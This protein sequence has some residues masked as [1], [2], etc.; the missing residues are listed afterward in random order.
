MPPAQPPKQQSPRPQPKSTS[1]HHDLTIQSPQP[2]RHPLLHHNHHSPSSAS[3]R[4][5][6]KHPHAPGTRSTASV[7]GQR[8][9]RDRARARLPGDS[10]RPPCFGQ[11]TLR[12]PRRQPPCFSRTRTSKPSLWKLRGSLGYYSQGPPGQPWSVA[13][14]PTGSTRRLYNLNSPTAS[15]RR[16]LVTHLETAS[17][18]VS[19]N[20]LEAL[21]RAGS[22]VDENGTVDPSTSTLSHWVRPIPFGSAE[23]NRRECDVLHTRAPASH[24]GGLLA[25]RLDGRHTPGD[26]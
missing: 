10:H 22:F 1:H 23:R 20:R 19:A 9:R 26:Q 25:Q 8:T 21:D 13:M 16:R 24:G 5:H 7:A 6:T 12:P 14:T 11:R 2:L 4:Q 17:S 3:A 18:S 15:R